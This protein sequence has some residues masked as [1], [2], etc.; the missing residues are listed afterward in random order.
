M[1]GTKRK[2]Y[3][4]DGWFA[5]KKIDGTM[6]EFEMRNESEVYVYNMRS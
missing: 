2:T 6:T 3:S 1:E 5:P 4:R